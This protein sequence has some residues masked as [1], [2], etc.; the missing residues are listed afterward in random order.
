MRGE[1]MTDV[2]VTPAAVERR[3]VA[4]SLEL[5]EAV[6]DLKFCEKEYPRLKA[7]LEVALARARMKV[8]RKFADRGE[9]STVSEREDQALL[10][11]SDE[12]FNV[13]IMEG[14]VRAARA[15]IDRLE[16]QIDLARSIGT[17]VRSA[18]DLT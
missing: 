12:V 5:D 4:L 1:P 17:S 18:M 8:G 15:N 11:C 13:A 16:K 3:M 6:E 14:R 9:K 2:V 10:D 7:E